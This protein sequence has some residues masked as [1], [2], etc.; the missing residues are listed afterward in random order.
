M[1]NY[2]QHTA[3]NTIQEE[4]EYDDIHGRSKQ[5]RSPSNNVEYCAAD[6]KLLTTELVAKVVTQ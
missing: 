2:V 6:N 3:S 4:T 1:A 5:D